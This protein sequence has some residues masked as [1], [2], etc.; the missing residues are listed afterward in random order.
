MRG[1]VSGHGWEAKPEEWT[2]RHSWWTGM[3]REAQL[4]DLVERH[5]WWTGLGGIACGLGW[6]A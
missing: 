3:G 2:R 5:S 4:L 6:A 1:T